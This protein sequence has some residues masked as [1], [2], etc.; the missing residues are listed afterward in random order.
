M[1]HKADFY[2]FA[3]KFSL[4][5]QSGHSYFECS[6]EQL[7]PPENKLPLSK[8]NPVAGLSLKLYPIRG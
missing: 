6:L 1:N 3:A 8:V 7:A 4:P 2:E 5:Y